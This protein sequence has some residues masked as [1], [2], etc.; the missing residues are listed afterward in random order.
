LASK[1]ELDAINKCREYYASDKCLVVPVL[2]QQKPN[3]TWTEKG[4]VFFIFRSLDSK[5]LLLPIGGRL[6]IE[7][8]PKF[9]DYDYSDHT[10]K[11]GVSSIR[12]SE[13]FPDGM[14]YWKKKHP[15]YN[16]AK[17]SKIT[18][19]SYEGEK[20]YRLMRYLSQAGLKE[21]SLED[22]DE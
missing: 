20:E 11:I 21:V 4:Q 12:G 13:W 2:P 16:P 5:V 17:D 15:G 22:K 18:V 6:L 14:K 9:F 1:A 7:H 10:R 3:G 19:Y 8:G